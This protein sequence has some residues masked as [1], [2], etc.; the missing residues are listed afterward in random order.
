MKTSVLSDVQ[1]L[2]VKQREEP[3]VNADD[4]L[5]EVNRVGICGSDLHYYQHGQNGDNVVD[6]PHVLGHEAAGTVVETGTGVTN[7]SVG[8]RVAI[9]PGKPCESCRYC[10]EGNYHLCESM[11]YLSSPPTDGALVERLA[12]PAKHVYPLPESVSLREGALCEPLSVAIHACRRAG[13]EENDSVLIT[14]AGPI[15]RLVAEV[16]RD[17]GAD[18]IVMTD[19]V[20]DKL[21]EAETAG[22]DITVNVSEEDTLEVIKSEVDPRGVDVAIESSG[23]GPAVE[24]VVDAI[25][26][27]GIVTFVGIPPETE[28]PLTVAETI[29]GEYD[30]RGSFRFKNT[31]P[32]A[33][34]GLKAG[35]Y[36][37]D[38][39]VSFEESLERTQEVFEQATEPEHV[40][41]V[42]RINDE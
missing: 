17:F 12:W 10:E 16:A 32:D 20:E 5:I 3:D 7:V 11:E 2:S 14:G 39:I 41:G 35:R 25:K 29:D 30:V 22:V 26:R 19:L 6:F 24:T 40:K 1:E 34:A 33:I 21:M 15:G 38:S 18:Q 4:V 28:V 36:D 8:D 13:V 23:A 37:V 9:D 31:Y 27:G 42:V